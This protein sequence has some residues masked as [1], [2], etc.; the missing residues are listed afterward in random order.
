MRGRQ[1]VVVK[2]TETYAATIAAVAP[3]IW[4]VAIIEFHQFTRAFTAN[5]VADA[6]VGVRNQ[7]LRMNGEP[8][9]EEVEGLAAA[10]EAALTAFGGEHRELRTMKRL[11]SFGYLVISTVLLVAESVALLWLS[12][13]QKPD[14]ASAWFCFIAVSVGFAAI[15]VL[16][17]VVA[18]S[19]RRLAQPG[20]LRD[21]LCVHGVL[22]RH[23]FDQEI[24]RRHGPTQTGA[25]TPR[26]HEGTAGAD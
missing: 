15:T 14:G 20:F 23:G 8:S 25:E 4:L 5:P 18:L 7:A 2:M 24:L 10:L 19:S 22:R 26:R 6:L 16:P 13:S 1:T 3:V 12:G 11:V 21:L 17:S 9:R